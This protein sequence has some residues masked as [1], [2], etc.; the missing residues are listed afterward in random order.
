MKSFDAF[1]DFD[2][3]ENGESLD[4]MTEENATV[5][6]SSIISRIAALEAAISTMQQERTAEKNSLDVETT[7]TTTETAENTVDNETGEEN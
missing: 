2:K 1:A 6:F 7:T 5:D 3:T 4:E